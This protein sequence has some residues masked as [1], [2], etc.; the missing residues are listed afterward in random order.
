M[1]TLGELLEEFSG[2]DAGLSMDRQ[3]QFV[4]PFP[5]GAPAI[6]A[7]TVSELGES[8]GFIGTAGDDD[9]EKLIIDRLRADDV[10]TSKIEVLDDYTTGT[11]F[12]TYSED[13]SRR[14]IFHLIHAAPD[15]LSPEDVTESYFSETNWLHMAA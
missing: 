14:F 8:C 11:S 10:D 13:E 2:I 7:A 3:R 4:G 1:I 6:F 9:F 15:Q 5:A 12:V